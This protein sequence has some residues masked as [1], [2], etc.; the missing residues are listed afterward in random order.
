MA[1]LVM[2]VRAPLVFSTDS[3]HISS[4]LEPTVEVS[5]SCPS[6]PSLHH[7]PSLH[8]RPSRSSNIYMGSLQ[9]PYYLLP[10]LPASGRAP[11]IQQ[12]RPDVRVDG[13][14]CRSC[15]VLGRFSIA[16]SMEC[17]EGSRLGKQ[18]R[19]QRTTAQPGCQF[20]CARHPSQRAKARAEGSIHVN[21]RTQ[22][23]ARTDS[24]WKKV[25]RRG[26][27]SS[28]SEEIRF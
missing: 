16:S 24:G 25:N 9:R 3:T 22:V 7:L 6:S 28:K 15:V 21:R 26:K 2:L 10:V 20:W 18:V 1:A 23:G 5:Y 17:S 27:I 4:D 14:S 11:R 8:A 13:H 19:F 12:E